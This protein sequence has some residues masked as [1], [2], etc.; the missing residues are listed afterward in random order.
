MKITIK[1]S[2]DNWKVCFIKV[3]KGVVKEAKGLLSISTFSYA[4]PGETM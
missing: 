4:I 2:G 1:F 3:Q